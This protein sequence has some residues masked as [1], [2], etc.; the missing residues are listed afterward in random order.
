MFAASETSRGSFNDSNRD[1]LGMVLT[2][3]GGLYEEKHCS[4]S[5]RCSS[6]AGRLFS[7]RSSRNVFR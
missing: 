6:L 7:P 5:T 4:A 2:A 1:R 3:K